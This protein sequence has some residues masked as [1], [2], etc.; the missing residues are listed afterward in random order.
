MAQQAYAL[1]DLL[2]P[3]KADENDP[4]AEQLDTVFQRKD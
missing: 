3:P 2:Y 1:A 4:A